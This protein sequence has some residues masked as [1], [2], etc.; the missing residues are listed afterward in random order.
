MTFISHLI[1]QNLLWES[2]NPLELGF[3]SCCKRLT[4]FFLCCSRFVNRLKKQQLLVNG[5]FWNSFRS[6]KPSSVWVSSPSI[7]SKSWANGLS[8]NTIKKQQKRNRTN[9]TFLMTFRQRPHWNRIAINTRVRPKKLI[10]ATVT[11]PIWT[12]WNRNLWQQRYEVSC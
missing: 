5:R 4:Y 11:D 7:C 9:Q 10:T 2:V 8:L 12:I 1:K 6:P 3:H